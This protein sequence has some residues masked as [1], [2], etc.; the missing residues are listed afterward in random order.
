MVIM[1]MINSSSCDTAKGAVLNQRGGKETN[2]VGGEE[3]E[4]NSWRKTKDRKSSGEIKAKQM[5][6]EQERRW[7]LQEH[8]QDNNTEVKKR[9]VLVSAGKI[10]STGSALV[11]YID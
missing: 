2:M 10:T 4:A 9:E 3:I 6:E 7:A 5:Q 1:T 11:K 8:R